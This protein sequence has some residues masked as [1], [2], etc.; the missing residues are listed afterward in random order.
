MKMDRLANKPQWQS[1]ANK[2]TKTNLQ[3]TTISLV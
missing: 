2:D 3:T 1:K